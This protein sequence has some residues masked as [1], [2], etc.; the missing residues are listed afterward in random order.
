MNIVLNKI[1]NYIKIYEK[2]DYYIGQ[3]NDPVY[4][5]KSHYKEKKFIFM[6]ILYNDNKDNIDY[7]EHEL[8]NVNYKNETC[9]NIQTYNTQSINKQI[10]NKI[11]NN[12]TDKL[13]YLYIL[14]PAI[15]T[16]DD[17]YFNY[18]IDIVTL[19]FNV[20]PYKYNNQYMFILNTTNILVKNN[21]GVTLNNYKKH[22]KHINRDPE[23]I[24]IDKI[25]KLIQQNKYKFTYFYIGRCGNYQ[26][27]KHKLICS[28]ILTNKIKQIYKSN[29][30]KNIIELT[31]RLKKIY[32]H[33]IVIIKKESFF[34]PFFD[35]FSKKNDNNIYIYF[36]NK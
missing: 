8:I 6:I 1:N 11:N 30:N 32:K 18:P 35:F 26:Q 15:I 3:T 22:K 29:D 7:L 34:K 17:I 10:N 24:C 28:G 13:H 33:N 21:K 4:R 23:R 12:D 16:I 25:D 27:K 5:L 19:K 36:Y 2:T 31:N 9:L 14:F 20:S